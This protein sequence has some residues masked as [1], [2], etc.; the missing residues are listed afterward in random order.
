MRYNDFNL[1]KLGLNL[2]K[3]NV[4]YCKSRLDTHLLIKSFL[5]D[6]SVVF[7]FVFV[8]TVQAWCSLLLSHAA[9]ST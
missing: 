3:V 7:V 8:S 4:M 9:E 6:V 1:F 2:L 5:L